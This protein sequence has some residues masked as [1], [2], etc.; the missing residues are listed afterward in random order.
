M[1]FAHDATGAV[2]A[3]LSASCPAGDSTTIQNAL[4]RL[5]PRGWLPDDAE[6]TSGRT[7]RRG[8]EQLRFQQTADGLVVTVVGSE[9]TNDDGTGLE[10]LR[11]LPDHI[12][13]TT[14]NQE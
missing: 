2:R 9:F 4:D 12:S 7:T 3:Q 13:L 10:E 14:S 11:F 1:Q 6:Q 5:L 8:D